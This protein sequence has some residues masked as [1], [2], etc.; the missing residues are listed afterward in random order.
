MLTLLLIYLLIIG[1]LGG[2]AKKAIKKAALLV[3]AA[4]EWVADSLCF[5]ADDLVSVRN[6]I[7]KDFSASFICDFAGTV[8]VVCC[9]CNHVARTN[10]DACYRAKSLLMEGGEHYWLFGFEAVAF[11]H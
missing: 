2:N 5:D 3:R 7:R 1:I 4:F 9:D 8:F 6:E 11:S 10:S